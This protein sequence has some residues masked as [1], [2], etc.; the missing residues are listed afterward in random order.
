MVFDVTF[1]TQKHIQQQVLPIVKLNAIN[2]S[3]K[4]LFMVNCNFDIW[5]DGQS[6]FHHSVIACF[7]E[8][9]FGGSSYSPTF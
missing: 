9:A 2:S 4:V 3:N 5:Q 7:K 6:Q 1:Y 8:N